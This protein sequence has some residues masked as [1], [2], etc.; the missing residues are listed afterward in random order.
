MISFKMKKVYAIKA[1]W[2]DLP[3]VSEMT[4][5]LYQVVN[6]HVSHLFDNTSLVGLFVAFPLANDP[7]YFQVLLLL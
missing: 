5:S 6:L 3:A 2:H 7:L 1:L 4:A